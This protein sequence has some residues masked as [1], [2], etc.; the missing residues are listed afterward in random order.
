[1]AATTRLALSLAALAA[2][3]GSA[4]AQELE[5]PWLDP[6]AV[7]IDEDGETASLFWDRAI[8]P[9]RQ[10]YESR[11]KRAEAFLQKLDEQSQTQAEALLRGAIQLAPDEP[12]AYWYLG[13][14]AFEAG[15]WKEC[16]RLR[17]TVARLEPDFEP[18]KLANNRGGAINLDLGLGQCLALDGDYEGALRRYKRMLSRGDAFVAAS[19]YQVRWR[20]GEAY[21]AL[22]R[23]DEAIASL[24]EARRLSRSEFVILY[25][26]AAAYDRNE[27]I[28]PTRE[29]LLEA[30]VRDRGFASLRRAGV[31]IAPP[32]DAIYYRALAEAFVPPMGSSTGMRR[33]TN[34]PDDR[35]RALAR[36]RHFLGQHGDGPWSRRARHHIEVLSREPLSTANIIQTGGAQLDE[37]KTIAAIEAGNSALQA[38]VAATPT[39]A[40]TVAITALTKP[41]KPARSRPRQ[42]PILRHGGSSSYQPSAGVRT[43]GHRSEEGDDAAAAAPIAA[44]VDCLNRAAATLKLPEP[45]GPEGDAVQLEFPVVSQRAQ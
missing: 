31:H 40:Y 22:G 34:S 18:P 41:A 30:R 21:M 9:H 24:K 6:D 37:A 14:M 10:L 12:R 23:L 2:L 26:L 35:A 33:G 38:C 45:T 20:M 28:A 11:V 32:E 7:D 43:M 25:A 5:R 42:P 39:V 4:V 44:A 15:D 3:S 27:Q 8:Y 29:L 13:V 16:A 1:M 17:T 19:S 36:F